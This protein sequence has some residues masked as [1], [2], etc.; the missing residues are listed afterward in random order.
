MKRL[1]FLV[2]FICCCHTLS[3]AQKISFSDTSNVW[4]YIDS[5]IGCCIPIPTVYTTTRYDSITFSYNG[6]TYR[7]LNNSTGNQP[8]RASGSRIY[9]LGMPD[10]VERVMYDF[11]LGVNDTLRTTYPENKYIAWVTS[12]DSTQLAGYWYKVWH[13]EGTD[14][15]LAFSDSVSAFSYNVIEG[16]GCTN[17]V[18]YPAAPYNLVAFSQQLLCFNN[19]SHISSALSSPVKTFGFDYFSYYDNN[20]S[21]TEFYADHGHTLIGDDEVAG[22][23]SP[24]RATRVVPN[25][26]TEAS[27]IELPFLFKSGTIIVV[28]ETGQIMS[29][30]N[31][32]NSSSVL[33]GNKLTTPGFYYYKV[34]DSETGNTYTGT[35]VH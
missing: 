28:N 35:L 23:N 21:C 19:G 4:S 34:T 25:P 3:F 13:F 29:S 30:I 10:S 1:L 20:A 9:V 16:I 17:G 32:T 18:F 11:S 2:S 27:V 8:V 14:S 22:I 6:Y 33:I 15:V 31:F 24:K 5:N 7:Y 12:I 26:T